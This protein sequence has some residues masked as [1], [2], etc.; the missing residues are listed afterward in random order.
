MAY[1]GLEDLT[2]VRHKRSFILFQYMVYFHFGKSDKSSIRCESK[3][4]TGVEEINISFPFDIF[5]P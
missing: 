5:I 3:V 4:L 1:S 2:S